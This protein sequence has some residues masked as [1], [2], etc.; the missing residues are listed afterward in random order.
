MD[1]F[2]ETIVLLNR[3]GFQCQGIVIGDGPLASQLTDLSKHLQI[4]EH[5]DFRGFV[6]PV[7]NELRTLDALIMPSDHEGLPMALLEA[8]GPGAAGNRPS[9]G[10]HPGSTRNLR[11]GISGQ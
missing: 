2:I 11:P 10:R 1:L 7:M 6:N 5:I 9:R 4:E 8:C 3:A